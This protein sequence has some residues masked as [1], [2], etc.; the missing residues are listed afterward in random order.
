MAFPSAGSSATARCRSRR[1][2]SRWWPCLWLWRST[3]P[4]STCE[5]SARVPTTSRCEAGPHSAHLSVC[6]RSALPRK[7]PWCSSTL[8]PIQVGYSKGHR[9]ELLLYL[10]SKNERSLVEQDVTALT[11]DPGEEHCLNQPVT[12]IE[13]HKLH[14][15]VG[16]GMHR[17]GRGQHS[18]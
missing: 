7:G 1:T 8:Q 4:R 16:L 10:A 5:R 12:I 17:L 18:S 6:V 15:L 3:P 9:A 2:R 13:R 11:I 14:R